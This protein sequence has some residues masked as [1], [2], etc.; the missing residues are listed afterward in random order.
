MADK[1]VRGDILKSIREFGDEVGAGV[2]NVMS[3][4]GR[5]TA[6]ALGGIATGSFLGARVLRKIV[7]KPSKLAQ[8]AAA[9]AG[10]AIGG[11][12]GVYAAYQG[13]KAKAAHNRKRR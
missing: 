6:L 13:E 11:P 10:G 4:G 12:I 7:R 8:R 5:H 2:E 3:H 9:T 1:T